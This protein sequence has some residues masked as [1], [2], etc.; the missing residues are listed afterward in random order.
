[1]KGVWAGRTEESDSHIVLLPEG[2]V[3]GK[4]LR[5]L[6]VEHRFDKDFMLKLKKSKFHGHNI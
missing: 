4:S 3:T 5:R 1:M 2:T 6:A